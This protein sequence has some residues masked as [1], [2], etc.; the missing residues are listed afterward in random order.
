MRLVGEPKK[1]SNTKNLDEQV[2]LI[3][4]I[5]VDNFLETMLEH[6]KGL[7]FPLLRERYGEEAAKCNW[8]S[9]FRA[10]IEEIRELKKV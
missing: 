7:D 8:G 10:A 2:A 3:R 4:S 6:N 5:G 9:L 1:V